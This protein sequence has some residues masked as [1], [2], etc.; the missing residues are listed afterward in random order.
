MPKYDEGGMIPGGGY[1]WRHEV[2]DRI[3]SCDTGVIRELQ[4]VPGGFKWEVT[5]EAIDFTAWRRLLDQI[6]ES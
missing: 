1:S 2:G 5:G 6:N 3:I 4:E